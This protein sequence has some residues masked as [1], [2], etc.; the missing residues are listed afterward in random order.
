[1][2]HNGGS[3]GKC[4][5]LDMYH[6]SKVYHVCVLCMYSVTRERDLYISVN[7]YNQWQMKS[8]VALTNMPM[9]KLLL[10]KMK[11]SVELTNMPMNKLLLKKK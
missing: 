2:V 10:K 9:N 3:S 4:P 5:S 7:R 6:H 11:S 1:M 8:S